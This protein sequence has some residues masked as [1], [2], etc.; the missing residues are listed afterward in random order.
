M[1]AI[2]MARPEQGLFTLGTLLLILGASNA[3][4]GGSEGGDGDASPSGDGDGDGDGTGGTSNND[5]TGGTSNDP[6]RP[7]GL[8]DLPPRDPTCDWQHCNYQCVDAMT[9]TSA[10]C[11]FLAD[12]DSPNGVFLAEDGMLYVGADDGLVKLDPSAPGTLT[13]VTT[14][15]TDYVGAVTVA[16]A[17][18]YFTRSTAGA[19]VFRVPTSGGPAEALMPDV[20][21]VDIAPSTN[22]LVATTGI[23][24]NQLTIWDGTTSADYGEPVDEAFLDDEF[25]YWSQYPDLMRAPLDDMENPVRVGDSVSGEFVVQGGNVY[26]VGLQRRNLYLNPD[27]APERLLW[28]DGTDSWSGDVSHLRVFPGF[29]DSVFFVF[30]REQNHH[31]MRWNIEAESATHV[32]VLSDACFSDYFVAGDY[33]FLSSCFAVYRVPL[34]PAN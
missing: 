27:G 18:A 22:G 2:G 31:L 9:P 4:S 28:E 7:E 3:C 1:L 6:A 14:D 29:D 19:G 15:D 11:D 12:I 5:G 17:T 30:E 23:L 21:A 16:G 32:A 10:H 34:P 25:A 26:S 8:Q 13:P 20:Y 33:A 24:G